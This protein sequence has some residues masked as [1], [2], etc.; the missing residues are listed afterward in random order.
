VPLLVCNHHEQ[1]I[2][3]AADTFLTCLPCRYA[4]QKLRSK[5]GKAGVK[6]S[7]GSITSTSIS[8]IAVVVEQVHALLMSS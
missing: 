8:S 4:S 6:L 2:D 7:W 1:P 3:T 5:L